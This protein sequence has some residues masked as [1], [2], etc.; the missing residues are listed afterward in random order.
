MPKTLNKRCTFQEDW[1][2]SKN[3]PEFFWVKK[4]NSV[5]EA[6]CSLC[7]NTFDIS[8]MGICALKSHAKGKKHSQLINNKN[9][10]LESFGACKIIETSKQVLNSANNLK[11][12]EASQVLK[13]TQNQNVKKSSGNMITNYTT[14]E[15]VTN[16]E[17]LWALNYVYK[18]LS[19][20]TASDSSELFPVMFPD[21][22]V[23]KKFQMHKDKICYV[24]SHGLGPYFQSELSK[25]IQ[26]CEFYTVSFDESLNKV[27]QKGQMDIIIRFWKNDQVNTRYLT[28]TFL[29]HATAA[30]LL[31]AFTKAFNDHD[32]NLS[33]MIQIS[34]DGPNVN[35]RFLSDL[36][37]VLS[38][39]KNETQLIDTGTCV[40]H[41]VNGAFKTAHNESKWDICKFLRSLYYLFKDSPTRRADFIHFT[42]SSQFPLKFCA[43]RWM[44]NSRVIERALIMIDNLHVFVKALGKKA[45]KSENYEKITTCLNDQL[46]KAKLSFMLSVSIEME[47][48][49]GKYQTDW[50]ML[51]FMR[52]DLFNL[53][54]DLMGRV[55]KD[56]I[57]TTVHS[58]KELLEIDLTKASNLYSAKLVNIGFA[59]SSALSKCKDLKELEITQFKIQCQQFIIKICK[60]LIE[61]CPINYKFIRG[62]SCFSPNVMQMES[63]AKKNAD[64]ALRYLVDKKLLNAI[65][66]DRIKRDYSLFISSKNVKRKLK[67]FDI[68]KD[69]LDSFFLEIFS[70]EKVSDDLEKFLKIIL[71][72]FHGNASVERSFSYNKDFLVE[73]LQEDS[74][75]AQRSVH[76]AVQ[77]VN[78]VKNLAITP[79]M[80]KA[81]SNASRNRKIALKDKENLVLKEKALKRKAA[82]ELKAICAKK[83]QLLDLAKEEAKLLDEKAEKLKKLI[84]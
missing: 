57:M 50:P 7:I 42:N 62:A 10:S 17:I 61:K 21:S 30:D 38:D 59:A 54:K 82:D 80:R 63:T 65:E 11:I 77:E 19:T 15:V 1:L 76:G 81:F 55:V 37:S 73:N 66:A 41:I 44:E 72:T 12:N 18:K 40:L 84:K 4:A 64:I 67:D 39:S 45:P 46:L 16:A 48:F 22:E 75:I 31:S 53:L 34:M 14:N 58:T 25:L 36:C 6:A 9:R 2:D 52:D 49:L 79:E 83:R 74:L 70:K 28:S 35:K 51:P 69:R 8:N 20:R 26:Q 43:V 68:K 27:A 71:V 60:K 29:G 13:D 24:I 56:N 23:A 3:H 78:G 47:P 33:K 32:I 5:T